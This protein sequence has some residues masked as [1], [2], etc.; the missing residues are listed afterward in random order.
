MYYDPLHT[1]RDVTIPIRYSGIRIG[2]GRIRIG[3]GRIRIVTSLHTFRTSSHKIHSLLE[4]QKN[5][6]KVHHQ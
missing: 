3:I 4:S 2:I 1:F 5:M 6:M